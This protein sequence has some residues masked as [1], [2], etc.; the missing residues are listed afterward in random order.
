MTLDSISE[1]FFSK[2]FGETIFPQTRTRVS[3]PIR[4]GRTA[5]PKP[6]EM[7]DLKY[8]AST[9]ECSHLIDSLKGREMFDAAC[10]TNTMASVRARIKEEKLAK[11]DKI[12]DRIKNKKDKK[13]ARK[14]DYL[15]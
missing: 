2:L 15:W 7:V 14:L 9:C 10:H 11:A 1:L 8:Q 6:E 12:L 5:I 3:V 13:G 4:Q